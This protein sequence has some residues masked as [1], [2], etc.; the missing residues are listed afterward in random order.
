MAAISNLTEK[1]FDDLGVTIG[2]RRALQSSFASSSSK[3]GAIEK[4]KDFLKAKNQ[5]RKKGETKSVAKKS[6]LKLEIGW[7]HK[8][9]DSQEYRQVKFPQSG[10]TRLKD[11]DRNATYKTVLNAG[12]DFFF[13]NGVNKPKS[14]SLEEIDIFLGNYSGNCVEFNL[15]TVVNLASKDIEKTHPFPRGTFLGYTS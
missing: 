4:L 12:K 15:L 2:D 11:F 5:Q 7:R 1:D 9:S 6:T 13:P 14:I 10:G 3:K 8:G